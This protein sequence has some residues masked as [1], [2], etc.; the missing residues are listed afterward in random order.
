MNIP[1]IEKKNPHFSSAAPMRLWREEDVLPFKSGR[2]VELHG[3]RKEAGRK[4]FETRKKNLVQWFT[5]IK[6]VNPRVREVTRRLWEIGKEIGILHDRKEE[7][8]NADVCDREAFWEYGIEHCP[9]CGRM[10][11]E[12]EKLRE[13]RAALFEEL[14]RICGKEKSVVQLARRYCR[15]SQPASGTSG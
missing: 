5:Q 6:S 8:R 12:Q 7:C 3:K 10:S 15:E 9:D 11:R 2:G 4:A 1:F 14:E 13:E